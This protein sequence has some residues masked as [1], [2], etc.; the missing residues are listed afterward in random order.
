MLR[1]KNFIPA[2]SLEGDEASTD[3]RRGKGTYQKVVQA[4]ELLHRKKLPYGISSCY[5]SANYEASPVPCWKIRSVCG[6]W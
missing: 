2:I 6:R 4:M 3:A 5:T 1:V